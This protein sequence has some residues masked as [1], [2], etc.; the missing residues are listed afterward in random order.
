M[1]TKTYWSCITFYLSLLNT[2]ITT[3]T[4]HLYK[5]PYWAIAFLLRS[6]V[7]SQLWLLVQ[8][9][10]YWYNMS[11]DGLDSSCEMSVWPFLFGY[12]WQ[13][14]NFNLHLF[15]YCFMSLSQ[16][17]HIKCWPLNILLSLI[18][19]QNNLYYNR[20]KENCKGVQLHCVHMSR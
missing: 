7:P 15:L 4:C 12:N 10:N 6:L 17:S 3:V 14:G 20:H 5:A 16:T 1:V 11:K 19:L 9:W 8:F 13:P 2:L 18:R